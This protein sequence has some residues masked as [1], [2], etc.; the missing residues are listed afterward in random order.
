VTVNLCQKSIE[1]DL[2]K[3][4]KQSSRTKIGGV[5]DF[6]VRG[7]TSKDKMLTEVAGML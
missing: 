5:G 6:L 2:L 3:H 4:S 1:I 7:G